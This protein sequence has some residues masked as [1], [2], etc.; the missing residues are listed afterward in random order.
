MRVAELA[1]EN[2]RRLILLAG[3]EVRRVML[4]N[5]DYQAWYHRAFEFAPQA[6]YNKVKMEGLKHSVPIE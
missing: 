3:D 6:R 4:K 2:D 1:R 5:N